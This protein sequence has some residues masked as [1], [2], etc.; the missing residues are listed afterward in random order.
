MDYLIDTNVISEIC[1]KKPNPAVLAWLNNH[2]EGLYLSSITIEELRFGELMMPQGK[3]RDAL[4]HIIN[5]LVE[6]YAGHVLPFDSD[7]AEVCAAFHRHAI[8]TGKTP[9]IEDLMIASIA[10]TKG[11]V[12]ATRNVCDFEYL[13]I[14]IENPFEA[15]DLRTVDASS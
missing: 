6:N 11:L 5:S 15:C 14:A 8:A 13:D 3:K 7:A 12:I 4:H 2:D 9:T 1:K 10:N